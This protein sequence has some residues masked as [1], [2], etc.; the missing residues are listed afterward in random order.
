M[1][2]PQIVPA[3]ACIVTEPV[4]M[5]KAVPELPASLLT[6]AIVGSEEFHVTAA[7]VWPVF[8]SLAVKY[9]VVPA[10][11]VGFAG[12]TVIDVRFAGTSVAG[13]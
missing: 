5:A 6:D 2:D 9:C 3:H 1:V 8:G 10:E 4:L 13:W 7:N 12:P 11:I